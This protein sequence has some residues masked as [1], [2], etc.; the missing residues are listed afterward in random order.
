MLVKIF[1]LRLDSETMQYD[2]SILTQFAR[3]NDVTSM[4]TQF[5]FYQEEPIWSVIVTYKTKRN[6]T[7]LQQAKSFNKPRQG[8]KLPKPKVTQEQE[9][10]YQRLRLWRNETAKAM[11]HPPSNL[12][13]NRQLRE[14]VVLNPR[15]SSQLT[16]VHGIGAYKSSTYGREILA[17]LSEIEDKKIHLETESVEKLTGGENASTGEE[18]KSTDGKSISEL[19]DTGEED[20]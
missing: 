5:F 3:E 14:I 17:L 13:N 19:L 4:K 11:G 18:S 1:N 12:L 8:E 20:E 6:I 7:A 9:E 10:A 15:S 16:K 2:D